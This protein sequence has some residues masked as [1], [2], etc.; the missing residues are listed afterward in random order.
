MVL[1]ELVQLLLCRRFNTLTEYELQA[2]V[3]KVLDAADVEFQREHRLAKIRRPIDFYLP[4]DDLAIECK[5]AGTANAV[6]RQ[7]LA[8]LDAQPFA[9]LLLL[10][11]KTA[12]RW[13]F[14]QTR[15]PTLRGVPFRV[16]Q[17][18]NL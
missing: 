8:Y 6:L 17:I 11:T 12:H 15:N 5:I 10:T 3:A 2:D 1:D 18:R 16:V 13:S 4:H 9:G 7:C 14:L